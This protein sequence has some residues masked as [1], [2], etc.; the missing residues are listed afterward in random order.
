MGGATQ[1]SVVTKPRAVNHRSSPPGGN[2]TLEATGLPEFMPF[3]GEKK[4]EETLSGQAD[5][6]LKR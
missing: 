2:G 5:Q 3:G 1:H 6:V 4:A